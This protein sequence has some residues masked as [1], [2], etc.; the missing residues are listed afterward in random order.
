MDEYIKLQNIQKTYYPKGQQ[1]VEAL[2]D[3]NIEIKR[4]EFVA[5]TGVSG[6]GK[7]TTLHILGFLDRPSQ[8]S[9]FFEKPFD[10][11]MRDKE[12]AALRNR[13]IGFILQDFGLIPD[14]TAFDNV[15]MPLQ[16]AGVHGSQKTRKVA[17]IFKK[18]S[19]EELMERRVSQMSGGQKQRVAIARALVND[20]Q[21]ILADEPTGAL[22]TVTKNEILQILMQIKSEGKTVVVVTHDPDVA[23]MADRLLH[24]SDGVLNDMSLEH[25]PQSSGAANLS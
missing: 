2:K 16:F 1:P 17:D 18:L 14:W 8:G 3:V 20:P 21:L 13:E 9:Q 25:F 10:L 7:S 24:I 19:I 22:D 11:K 4:G 12:M 6:S 23:G 15:A 5:I